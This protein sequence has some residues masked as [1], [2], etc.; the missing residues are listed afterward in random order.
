MPPRRVL[1]S[2]STA[3]QGDKE[4]QLS[5]AANG[6]AAHGTTTEHAGPDCERIELHHEQLDATQGGA[7]HS[8][9]DV[10]AIIADKSMCSGASFLL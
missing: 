8:E 4:A 1:D 7:R 9:G 10:C 5:S 6:P 3:A 2:R